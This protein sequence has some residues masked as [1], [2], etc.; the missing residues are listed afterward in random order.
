MPILEGP[1]L[2]AGRVPRGACRH[3]NVRRNVPRHR[4]AAGPY[5]RD[6][7]HRAGID[8]T[9]SRG[10]MVFLDVVYNHFG[11][12]GNYLG[13][14]A[15]A[16]FSSAQTPW[17]GAIDY[18]VPEVRAYAIENAL[19]WLRDYRFDGL[20]LDAVHTIVTPGEP[21]ILTDLSPSGSS[22]SSGSAPAERGGSS[23][24]AL[25]RSS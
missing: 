1:A 23:P 25:P 11:P 18:R 13:R 5:R 6:R 12:E 8:A 21:S 14:I 4:R 10:L 24:P 7:Y 20:R 3:L 2:G 9:H 17:G 16:F 19:H 15:P 22:A